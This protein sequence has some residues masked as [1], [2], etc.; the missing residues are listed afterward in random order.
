MLTRVPEEKYLNMF[1]LL[2]LFL[3]AEYIVTM[4]WLKLYD[5]NTDEYNLRR[6]FWYGAAATGIAGLLALLVLCAAGATKYL[7]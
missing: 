3:A 1:E 6:L 7:I 5:I 2:W 4:Q